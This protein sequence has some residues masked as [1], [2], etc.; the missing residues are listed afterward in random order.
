MTALSVVTGA[1]IFGAIWVAHELRVLL[2]GRGARGAERV[3][4]RRRFPGAVPARHLRIVDAPHPRLCGPD[5]VRE[6][7]PGGV[8]PRSQRPARAAVVGAVRQS[9]RSQSPRCSSPR[10][11]W[12]VA[13]PSLPEHR[14]ADVAV[15]EA[16]RPRQD[17]PRPSPHRAHPSPHRRRRRGADLTFSI[18]PGEMVGYIGPN[19]AG[20]ST[21]IKMLTGILVPSHGTVA[22]TASTPRATGPRSRATSASCSASA[23]SCG[24][25]CRSSTAS[26]LLRRVYRVGDAEY[27]AS[28][29]R[30]GRAARP[31]RSARGAG[32][33]VVAWANACAATSRPR[34][35]TTRRSCISTNRPSASTS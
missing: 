8:R 29:R 4:L 11:T 3:H 25:T 9:L 33:S 7:L 22:S 28:T 35:C 17:V 20:K 5:R 19:G 1:T 2:V 24:G 30:T 26:T 10:S 12:R 32:A 23:A 13:R 14:A 31:R 21:T 34:C 6:L 15:I 27:Q 16:T 18:E